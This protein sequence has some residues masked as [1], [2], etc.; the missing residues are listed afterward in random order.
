MA[1]QNRT[2]I[3]DITRGSVIALPVDHPDAIHLH[4]NDYIAIKSGSI[5]YSKYLNSNPFQ[6]AIDPNNFINVDDPVVAPPTLNELVDIPS[7]SD[8]E[9]VTYEPY[10]DPIT[11]TQK[12]RALIKIRNS[13][14][15]PANIA[16]VDA[17]I[18]NPS[19]VV[20]VLSNQ[21]T[22]QSVAFTVPN[23]GTPQVAFKRD[24]TSIAW[25]WNNV[26][27]LGSY[28]S[29]QYEWIISSTSSPT[30]PALASGTLPYSTSGSYQIGTNGV[31][32]TYRV[33]S[34]D[35]DIPATSSS[36]W[37]R[38]RAVVVGTNN[39]TYQ[40]GYSVPI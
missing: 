15:N 14:L 35:G 12:V 10:Y 28:S 38:V 21:S 8:I 40:S 30:A 26:T 25:G 17:R 11:K 7:L 3:K 20:P 1:K 6:F 39:T 37:L 24:G 19:T 13:S 2:D 27:G 36:R 5:D 23:P 34:R 9:S 16:G 22:N 29:V 32:K 4:P 18:F 31:R 33:S